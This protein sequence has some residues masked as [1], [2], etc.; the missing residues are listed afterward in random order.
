MH[1]KWV[2]SWRNDLCKT[3]G[4]LKNLIVEIK[5]LRTKLKL[6]DRTCCDEM[7]LIAEEVMEFGV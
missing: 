1:G 2:I 4:K 3:E 5:N 7:S 6:H